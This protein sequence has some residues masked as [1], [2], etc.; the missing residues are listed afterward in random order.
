MKVSAIFLIM[1]KRRHGKDQ[2]QTVCWNYLNHLPR[3]AAR[4][5]A[6]E[7]TLCKLQGATW[8]PSV[9]PARSLLL[10]SDSRVAVC[11][12]C[13][14]SHRNEG[15]CF[16]LITYK[17]RHRKDQDQTVC[18][19]Y[20]N[21][22]QRHAKR[23]CAQVQSFLPCISSHC[24]QLLQ[25]NLFNDMS[26]QW[27]VSPSNMLFYLYVVWLERTLCKLQG[28]TWG[29][30]V[31]VRQKPS[32][33]LRFSGSCVWSM[34]PLTSEWRWVLCFSSHAKEDTERTKTRLSAGTISITCNVMQKDVVRKCNLFSLVYHRIVASSCSKICSM[35]CLTNDMSHPRTCFSISMWYG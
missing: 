25:Q 5:C 10:H 31:K 12:Q 4:C 34:L 24:R 26:H 2:D 27:H 22:L 21:H 35:T 3:H 16:F 9:K 14:R 17:R 1:C 11:D 29:P 23:C 18:W 20:L 15:E 6:L 32:L 19:N 30:S 8:G 28:A 33:A 7:K 13:F